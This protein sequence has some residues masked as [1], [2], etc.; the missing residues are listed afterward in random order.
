MIPLNLL[1][2]VENRFADMSLQRPHYSWE[3]TRR[4]N[5]AE[6][7]VKYIAQA[8]EGVNVI[9]SRHAQFFLE[10]TGNVMNE[11]RILNDRCM[12][13]TLTYSEGYKKMGVLI[14]ELR[15]VEVEVD[16]YVEEAEGLKVEVSEVLEEDEGD[17]VDFEAE[18]FGRIPGWSGSEP[19][20]PRPAIRNL[21][22]GQATSARG[23]SRTNAIVRRRRRVLPRSL[24]EERRRAAYITTILSPKPN[25]TRL[26]GA[27]NPLL[28]EG[29]S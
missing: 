24:S 10:R 11:I 20:P 5:Y 2:S 23:L 17:W 26:L 6:G 8:I 4:Y 1:R 25:R 16:M 29:D 12:G 27:R 3:I 21:N 7:L 18:S 22:F 19:Q 13:R 15:E 28:D 9:N 14:K